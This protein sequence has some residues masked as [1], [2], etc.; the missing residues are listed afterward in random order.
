VA[1]RLGFERGDTALTIGQA[2]TGLSAYAKD[3]SLGII[4]PQPELVRKRSRK[5]GRRTAL[6]RELMVLAELMGN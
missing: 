6:C 1:E 2:M 4:E 3:V 5:L